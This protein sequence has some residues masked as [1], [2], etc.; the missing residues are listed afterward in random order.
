[1][2][3]PVAQRLGVAEQNVLIIKPSS[4]GDIVHTLP[5]VALLKRHRPQWKLRWLVNPEWAPLLAGNPDLEPGERG[6]IPFPRGEFRGLA[7]LPRL[8]KWLAAQRR[9]GHDFQGIAD[10]QG[11]SRSALSAK[12][13]RPQWIAGLGDARE[14]AG[15]LYDLRVPVGRREHSVRR[16]LRLAGALCGQ[17]ALVDTPG[18]DLPFPLPAG[19]PIEGFE[20]D[21]PYLVLHPFSRGQDKSLAP[22]QVGELCRR[23][24]PWRIVVAGK[25]DPELAVAVELPRNALNLLNCTSLAQFIWLLRAAHFTLSVDSGPMHIAAALGPRVLGIHTWSNPAQVGPLHPGAW[26]WKAGELLSAAACQDPRYVCPE[27]TGAPDA[28]E[29]REIA[30]FTHNLLE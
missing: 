24:A 10:F 17:P 13:L 28:R 7:G 1:M 3:E 25:C 18:E 4:L 26:I 27:R 11:L 23:L 8:G 16:Y 14:G 22:A 21:P 29:I 30:Q 5:A 2:T 12:W 9:A 19:D 6:S 15:F 20:T